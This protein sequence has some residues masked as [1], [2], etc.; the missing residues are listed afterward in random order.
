MDTQGLNGEGQKLVVKEVYIIHFNKIKVRCQISGNNLQQIGDKRSQTDGLV[1]DPDGRLFMQVV[2]LALS[3][4]YRVFF[5]L[6]RPK[7]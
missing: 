3:L 6:V 1:I 4:I 5:L 7:K 2:S